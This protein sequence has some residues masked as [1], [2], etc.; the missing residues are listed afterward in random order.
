LATVGLSTLVIELTLLIQQLYY[1]D[2]VPLSDIAA[3]ASLQV[4]HER[5]GHVNVACVMR[6]IK[7]KD[8]DALKCSSMAVKDVCEPCVSGKAAMTPMPSAGGLRVSK[9]LQLCTRTWAGQCQSRRVAVRST[10]AHSPTT[11]PAGQTG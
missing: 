11:S 1:L 5:L 7:N 2:M 6:M 8:F 10:S 3:V 9:R 4:W